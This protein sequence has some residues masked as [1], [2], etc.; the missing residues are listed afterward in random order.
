MVD[1][2]ELELGPGVKVSRVTSVSEDLS[3]ALCGVPI[4]V[5]YPMRGKTTVGIEVPRNPRLI[6]YLDEVLD[7]LEFRQ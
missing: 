4:P 2:F 7:S 5:V 1:T 3:L 6:I